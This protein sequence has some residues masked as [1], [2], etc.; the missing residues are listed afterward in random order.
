MAIFGVLPNQH[1]NEAVTKYEKNFV[2]RMYI[3]LIPGMKVPLVIRKILITLL[4]SIAEK[5]FDQRNAAISR[6]INLGDQREHEFFRR[7]QLWLKILN[8]TVAFF[9][10]LPDKQFVTISSVIACLIDR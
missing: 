3:R 1:R 8:S 5:S 7:S 10:I 6:G 2:V 9:K 4:I